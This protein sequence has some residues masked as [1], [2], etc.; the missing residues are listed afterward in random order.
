[1][2]NFLGRG[3]PPVPR[4][5]LL[6]LSPKYSALIRTNLPRSRKTRLPAAGSA[7]GG[8]GNV[9]PSLRFDPGEH[10]E[11]SAGRGPASSLGQQLRL[12]LAQVEQSLPGGSHERIRAPREV[13][14]TTF[15]KMPCSGF[16]SALRVETR[17]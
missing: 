15:P 7:Q 14:G 1:M 6:A 17:D 9:V 12:Q 16:R 13:A 10:P 4:S 2:H 5:P 11:S 8:L 3:T